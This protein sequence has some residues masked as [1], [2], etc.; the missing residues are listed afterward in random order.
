M[1]KLLY[2]YTSAVILLVA[3]FSKIVS[4]FEK[5]KFLFEPNPVFAFISNR[6]LLISAAVLEILVILIL[7]LNKCV[8]SRILSIFWLSCL[9]AVYRLGLWWLD[10]TESCACV[11]YL[12]QWF[13]LKKETVATMSWCLFLYLLIPSMIFVSIDF[14]KNLRKGNN[15]KFF[16]FATDRTG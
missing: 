2:I 14:Y 1:V 8:R 9:F 10:V 13:K 16:H 4:Y 15:G 11:G 6:N 3:S 12:G 5:Q 7:I